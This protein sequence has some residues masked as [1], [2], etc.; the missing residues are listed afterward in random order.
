MTREEIVAMFE[1]RDQAWGRR[2]AAALEADYTEDAVAE[3]PIHG[4]LVGRRR[5]G[6]IYSHWMTAFPDVVSKTNDLVIDGHR[7]VQFVTMSGTQSAAFGNIPATGRKFQITG[8]LFFTLND[9]GRITQ[10]RRLYDVT[11][12]LVQLGALRTKPVD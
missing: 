10:N 1:R 8:A 3:S 7:V 5:I 11:N 2:D 9:E 12:M 4:R 6:E